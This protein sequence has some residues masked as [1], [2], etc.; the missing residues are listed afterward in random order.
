MR[1]STARGRHRRTCCYCK[2]HPAGVRD[3]ETGQD[4]CL[5][6]ARDL[7]HA[8]DPIETFREF[9]EGEAY[10]NYLKDNGTSLFLNLRKRQ[11]GEQP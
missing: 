4:W 1:Q 11:N 9:D 10:A 8:G 2:V 6:C 5:G 7:V 3:L